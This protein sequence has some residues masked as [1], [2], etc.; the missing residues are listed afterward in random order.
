LVAIRRTEP[1]LPI[2]H[3]DLFKDASTKPTGKHSFVSR[4]RENPD[5]SLIDA[6][7]LATFRPRDICLEPLDLR[8]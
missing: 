5:R 8:F 2:Q 6:W 4:R 1:V 3:E 7:V